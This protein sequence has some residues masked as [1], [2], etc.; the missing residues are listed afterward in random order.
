MK[1]LNLTQDGWLEPSNSDITFSDMPSNY[2]KL[3]EVSI[4]LDSNVHKLE[5]LASFHI[6]SRKI[7]IA[8]KL[9]L[10]QEQIKHSEF[11]TVLNTAAIPFFLSHNVSKYSLGELVDKVYLPTLRDKITK[12]YPS[13][14]VKFSSQGGETQTEGSIVSSNIGQ[15]EGLLNMLATASIV[16]IY[17]PLVLEGYSPSSQRNAYARMSNHSLKGTQLCLSGPLEILSSLTFNPD[18]LANPDSYSHVLC[19]SGVECLNKKLSMC[20]KSYGLNLEVWYLSNRLTPEIEQVSEQW[21]GGLTF[22][23]NI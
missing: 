3:G 2:Y 11:S 4:N 19:A 1:T 15:Y 23:T 7:Q 9:S 16:G 18:M 10:L 12:E 8:S 21:T 5:S 22:Y 6:D 17:C 13:R 14:Y 20:I